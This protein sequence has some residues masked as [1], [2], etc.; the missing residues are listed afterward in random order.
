MEGVAGAENEAKDECAAWLATDH[1]PGSFDR[2]P[3]HWPLVFPEVF[4]AGG[5]DAVIGNPP[6][7]GGQKL[8]GTLGPAY[9]EYLVAAIGRGAR[10]SADLVAYFA[11]RA[12]DLLNDRGQTGLIA[13]NT[14]AQGDTREVGLDQV[15]ESGATIRQSVKSEPWPSRSAA[16]EYCAVWTSKESLDDDAARVADGVVVA[17]ITSSL[18]VAS[19]T[20]GTA[21]RLMA[22]A[23]RSFQGSI[24]LGLGFTMERSEAAALIDKDPR[25][26]DVLFPYLNG[27]DLNSRPDCSGR[28]WI[29]NFHD[30]SLDRARTYPDCFDQVFRLVK[31]ERDENNRKVYGDY[32]WHYAEKRPAMVKAIRGLDRV[33]VITL[34]SKTAMPAVVPTS[35]VIDQTVVVFATSDLALLSL[36]SSAPHYAW[37]AKHSGTFKTDFRYNPSRIFETSALPELTTEMRDLGNRLHTFRRESVM[38]PRQAGLTATYNL[39]NNEACKDDDI[40]E[41]RSI[42]RAID[43]AVC[44]AYDWD[45]LVESGLDHGFH[46]VGRE[47]RYTVGPA[48]QREFVDRLLE[49]NHERYAAEVAAG[50]HDKKKRPVET[51]DEGALF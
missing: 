1:V 14:L 33:V 10:G 2:T 41:L 28:R 38:L 47:I 20:G 49:L 5:F 35:Q 17:A 19:R 3:L 27:Q 46:T 9:R 13:T 11:L 6:F 36:L 8:T 29:I 21:H 12:N 51:N 15:V 31:P 44:R 7:L 23:G 50:L 26:L 45:D 4:E 34:T 39:V 37:G 25:N 40:V 48:L 43:E 32:W 22:N 16:L 42:H 30:W 18:D 24:V